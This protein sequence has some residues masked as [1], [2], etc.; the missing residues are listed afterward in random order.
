MRKYENQGV[1]LIDERTKHTDTKR[2]DLKVVSRD[3]IVLKAF[4][5]TEKELGLVEQAFQIL[6][7]RRWGTV[8]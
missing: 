5:L 6:E 7:D 1:V 8:K 4:S 3:E 2:Y